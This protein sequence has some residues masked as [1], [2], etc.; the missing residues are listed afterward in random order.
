[1]STERNRNRKMRKGKN[2]ER[3]KNQHKSLEDILE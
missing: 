3:V 1:M 2:L